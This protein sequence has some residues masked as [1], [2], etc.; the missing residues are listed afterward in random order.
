M[1]ER[2]PYDIVY[3]ISEEI[4]SYTPDERRELFPFNHPSLLHDAAQEAQFDLRA[5]ALVCRSWSMPASTVNVRYL[6]LRRATPETL[7][8]ALSRDDRHLLVQSLQI[9]R[10]LCCDRTASAQDAGDTS[11]TSFTISVTTLLDMLARCP[12][13]RHLAIHEWLNPGALVDYPAYA[14]FSNITTFHLGQS[15][16]RRRTLDLRSFCHLLRLLPSL[17]RL[18]FGDLCKTDESI[19]DIPS[20]TFA[21][22]SLAVSDA[23]GIYFA[24]YEWLLAQSTHSLRT[25]WVY[26]VIGEYALASVI[27][28]LKFVA[29]S[30]RTLYYLTGRLTNLDDGILDRCT[31]L[32]ELCIDDLTII[33]TSTIHTL[34][35]LQKLILGVPSCSAD[36]AEEGALPPLHFFHGFELEKLTYLLLRPRE[37][38]FPKLEVVAIETTRHGSMFYPP[39]LELKALRAACDARGVVFDFPRM[40][41]AEDNYVVISSVPCPN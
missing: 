12:N 17:K 23:R 11:R 21:I 13:V 1:M 37:E 32:Q 38:V 25:F 5:C 7:A 40:Q 29:P 35:S 27:A 15:S 41:E 34:R 36:P 18:A 14:G 33:P 3:R 39:L 22:E 16:N 30:L 9:G 8:S 20:P 4:A 28:S 24:S 19:A 10:E 26:R 31:Q 6:Y 2:L